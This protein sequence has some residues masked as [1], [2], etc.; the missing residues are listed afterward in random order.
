MPSKPVEAEKKRAE[1]LGV[2]FVSFPMDVN[3]T[4]T[5]DEIE[6]ILNVMEDPANQPLLIHCFHGEDRTGLLVGLYRFYQDKW[7]PEA[8]YQEM[9]KMGFHKKFTALKDY[10]FEKTKTP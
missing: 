5:D 2:K 1:E 8:A 3:K 6:S 10:F 7:T 4:P 9:L